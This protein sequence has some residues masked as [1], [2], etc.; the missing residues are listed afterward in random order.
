MTLTTAA[1]LGADIC[2][3]VS[4]LVPKGETIC[5]GLSGGLDSTVLLDA[6]SE[7]MEST[8]YPVSAVHVNHNISPNASKWVKFCERLCANAGVP[9]VVE[10]VRIDGSSPEGLEASARIARYAVFSARPEK[11]VALAHHLDDQAE[12]VLLQLLRGTGLKGISAMP[13]IRELRGTPVSIVRP[14]LEYPR[15]AL[16]AYARGRELKWIED[17]SNASTRQ[18]RNY[19]RHDILPLLDQR[20]GGWREAMARFARHAG[21]AND[22]LEQLA[23]ADGVP[24]RAGD[25]FPITDL[26]EARRANALRGFLTRNAV[27]M[28][29]EARLAEMVRQLWEARDDARVRIDHAGVSLVRFKSEVHIERHLA[30]GGPW[31]VGWELESAVDLG[32]DRGIIEFEEVTGEGIAAESVEVGK[33]YFAPRSGG[34]SIRLGGSG[35][36]TRT[37]KNLFQ[38]LGVPTWQRE[39]LPLLFHDE[40]LVWVPGV[41]IAAEYACEPGRDGFRPT[42]RVAGKAPLC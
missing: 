1:D 8:G 4:R 30:S 23:A 39:K 40:R 20:F 29:S 42:W 18:D 13:E 38:E 21:S 7:N 28:P 36:P 24:L 22:L 9:L 31:R 33:W 34:E 16:E 27:A 6:L 19:L 17:E 41:G 11:F 2:A 14:M 5:V 3:R 35:R 26:R 32:A 12:T 37:L 25:P 15:A 10:E